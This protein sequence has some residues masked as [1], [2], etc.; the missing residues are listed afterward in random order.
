VVLDMLAR[1]FGEAR[2]A[3]LLR[4]VVRF[5]ANRAIS[6]DAFLGLLERLSGRDLDAFARQFVRGTGLPEIYYTYGFEPLPEGKWRI[7]GTARQQAP[8]R[9][10][11]RVI[12]GRDGGFDVGRETVAQSSIAESNL[13]VPLQVAIYDP[14]REGE[15]KLPTPPRRKKQEGWRELGNATLSTHVLLKGETTAIALDLDYEPKEL[16]LDR[17]QEVFGLFFNERRHPKRILYYQCLDHDAAGRYSEAEATCE[18]ALAAEPSA[19]PRYDDSP[20]EEALEAERRVLDGRVHLLLARL[21]LDA[22]RLADAEGS[23]GEAKRLLQPGRRPWL[24]PLIRIQEAR[25]AVRQGRHEEAFRLLRKAVLRRDLE[26]AEAAVLLAIAAQASGHPVELRQAMEEAREAG[27][28]V[29]L[30]TQGP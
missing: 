11:Y 6:T 27:A 17:K 4:E 29:T 26:S 9:F 14:G 19:G 5:T 23:I 12:A 16:W 18:Q 21:A 13:I 7:T 22:S 1:Y 10:R 25:L 8:W 28:D 20:G 24:E 2:F 30:L 15:V 3:E